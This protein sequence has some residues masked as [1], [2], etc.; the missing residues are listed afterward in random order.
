[1]NNNP[2]YESS[3]I[4]DDQEIVERNW[5][6]IL[7]NDDFHSFDEVIFQLQKATGC[8]LEL[9]EHVANIAHTEGEAVAYVASKEKCEQ[10]ASILQQIKLLVEIRPES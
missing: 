9:A 2:V 5:N 10:V 8:S 1:M 7:F 6:V 3:T 4:L